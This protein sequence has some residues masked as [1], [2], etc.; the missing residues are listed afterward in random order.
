M[1]KI[2]TFTSFTLAE[3]VL[4]N[5]RLLLDDDNPSDI[6][7]TNRT[8]GGTGFHATVSG[9]QRTATFGGNRTAIEQ[10]DIG[11][12]WLEGSPTARKIESFFPAANAFQAAQAVCNWL[13]H[14]QAPVY[15]TF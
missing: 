1:S 14:G 15:G 11:L 4:T 3:L 12:I 2:I 7:I 9:G 6:Y 5:M 8:D 13:I 10:I